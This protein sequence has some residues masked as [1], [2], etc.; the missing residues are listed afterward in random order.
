MEFE[1]Q[2]L[3]YEDYKALG[4][5]L[6]DQMP[7]NLLEFESRKQIDKRTQNRLKEIEY[8]ELPQEVKLCDYALINSVNNYL[9]TTSNITEKGNVASES[10]D[11]YS[12]SYVNAS[13]ISDI[14][15]SKSSELDDIIRTYLL[16][17]IVNDEHV[18][19][20]GVDK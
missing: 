4:G 18:M 10:T 7:F 15:K 3:T 5:T 17:L 16:G 2:Y 9:V 8:E 6:N 19:Y 14:I 11:G 1:G 20:V 13:Q 12:I